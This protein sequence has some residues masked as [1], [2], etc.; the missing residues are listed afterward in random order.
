MSFSALVAS[1]G[2]LFMIWHTWHYDRWRRL[3]Y[4]KQDWFRAIMCHIL[5]LSILSLTI[6]TWIC[7]HVLYSEYYVFIPQLKTTMVA[8]WQ[9]WSKSHQ[10][11]WRTALY[12]MTAGWGFLQAIH[13]EEFLYWGY[14]IK[15]IKTPGGPKSNWIQSNF[16]KL[17]IFLSISSFALLIGSV[18]IETN[19]LDM[20]RAYL[21]VVGSS[22]STI[23]AIASIILCVIFPSF[24]RTVKRQGASYEVLER[25]H[26]FSEMNDIRTFCRCAY[27]VAI[28]IL[29]IDGLTDA[30]TINK[31]GF[32]HDV[33]YLVGQL[34]L[35]SATCLSIVVLLPRNMTSESLPPHGKNQIFLPMAPYKKR[36]AQLPSSSNPLSHQHIQNKEMDGYSVKQFYELGER[37]NVGPDVITSGYP[38]AKQSNDLKDGEKYEM[39]INPKQSN[40]SN[41]SGNSNNENDNN[42]SNKAPFSEII[43][44][45]KKARLSEF[46]NLPSVVS[47][48]KSPFETTQPKQKGPTQV[49]VTSTTVIEESQD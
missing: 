48:F 22:M 5:L 21:F 27:S 19:N 23:L 16:F 30:R 29:S 28:L 10:S 31:S 7:V 34:A 43:D 18:H 25:L 35:F 15:S 2:F 9:L 33:L 1:T 37:L 8:P 20:M 17:W 42:E 13:L 12:F 46:P 6:Y 49:F 40:N 11:A 36:Q 39:S 45:T 38:I 24:L 14:L 4:S 32:W 44:K 41:N 47:K 26:F 3:L